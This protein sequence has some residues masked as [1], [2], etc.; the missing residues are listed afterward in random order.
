MVDK[1]LSFT[2]EDSRRLASIRPDRLGKYDRVCVVK[3]SSGQ[4]FA[5]TLPDET[6]NESALVAAVK[7]EIAAAAG[8]TGKTFTL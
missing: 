8:L 2:L 5:V 1:P 3:L 7:A 6:F 4:T